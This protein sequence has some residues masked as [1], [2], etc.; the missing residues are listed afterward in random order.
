MNLDIK[1][2]QQGSRRSCVLLLRPL[3][4]RFPST[5]SAAC[6]VIHNRSRAAA[7]AAGCRVH[8]LPRLRA[9]HTTMCMRSLKSRE[10]VTFA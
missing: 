5:R 9:L 7:L 3:C 10:A 4:T 2:S 6:V 1:F 8:L